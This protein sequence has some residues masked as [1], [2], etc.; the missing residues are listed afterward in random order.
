[1][2]TATAKAHAAMIAGTYINTRRA[3]STFIS[4]IKLFGT[5]SVTANADGTI[6]AAPVGQTARFVEVKPF[7]WQQLD[8]HDRIE[9]MV[10]NG[11]VERWSSDTVSPIVIYERASGI[12]GSGLEM[13]LGIASLV[14]LTLTVIMWPVVALVRRHYQRPFVYAGHRALSSR[15][16]RI[17]AALAMVAI[18]LWALVLVLVTAT[19]GVGVE[20]ILHSAQ[21]AS[22]IAFAGGLAVAAWNL[23]LFLKEGG[24]LSK[25]FAASLAAA[26]AV[27]L[28]ISLSYHL[29]GISGEY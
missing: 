13:P 7:L 22:L 20:F 28:W 18:G 12:A 9:G 25:L 8:S 16:V 14:L 2:D 19:N 26:F 24:W 6:T 11:R 27:M 21:F 4:L 29:I 3:D 10:K 5:S 23:R 1:V 15:L 17:C